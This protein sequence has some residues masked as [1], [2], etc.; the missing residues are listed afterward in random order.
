VRIA[1]ETDKWCSK[2]FCSEFY[3]LNDLDYVDCKTCLFMP[4]QSRDKDKMLQFGVQCS[5][6]NHDWDALLRCMIAMMVQHEDGGL[7][8]RSRWCIRHNAI[9]M[10]L[11]KWCIHYDAR[12]M[13]LA[14]YARMKCMKYDAYAHELMM[15]MTRILQP[16]SRNEYLGSSTSLDEDQKLGH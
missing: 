15:H 7:H 12:M 13:I 14:M 1:Q 4:M 9:I 8:A 16:F 10:M 11:T 3:Y 2:H 6:Y 5:I